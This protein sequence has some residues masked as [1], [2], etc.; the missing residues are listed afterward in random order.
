MV[1]ITGV[2]GYIGGQIFHDLITLKNPQYELTGLLRDEK[3][4]EKLRSLAGVKTV[5]GDLDTPTL[6][7]IA[8]NFD[9]VIHMA[10]SDHPTGAQAIAIG[11]ERR[12]KTSARKPIFI[13]TSG[14]GVLCD[15]A[16]GKFAAEKVYSD[17]DL[18]SYYALPSTALHKNVDDIVLAAGDRGIIDAIIICPPLIFGVGHG[19]FRKYSIQIPAVAAA[20]LSQGKAYTV[21]RGTNLWGMIHIF[22]ISQVYLTILEAAINGNVPENPR[23]RYYFGESGEFTFQQVAHALGDALYAKGALP[24]ADVSS[25]PAD[26]NLEE[27]KRLMVTGL[28]QNSRSK[29]VKVRKLGWKPVHG[30]LKEFLEDAPE[31]VDYVLG[32]PKSG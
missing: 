12:A 31:T 8:S 4:A 3:R 1:L 16:M 26:E 13:H 21:D 11:L 19:I 5:I 2:T 15:N 17:D 29:G 14:T 6:P 18:S 28:L 25:V 10:S 22:D 32:L 27:V 9:V 24:S 23:D 30:G 20:F 7:D